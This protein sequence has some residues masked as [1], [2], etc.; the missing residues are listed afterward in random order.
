[1]LLLEFDP[2]DPFT[3]TN[4]YDIIKYYWSTWL[5]EMGAQDPQTIRNNISFTVLTKKIKTFI[6]TN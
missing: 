5:Q 4:E 6:S 2:K 3:V 1:M